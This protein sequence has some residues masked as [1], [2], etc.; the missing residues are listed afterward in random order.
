MILAELFS[1]RRWWA[2]VLKEFLQLRRDRITFA[3]IVAIPFI[4]L[5]LFGYAINSDPKHQPTVIVSDDQ[6]EF[7][8]SFIA[9]LAHSDYF[10]IKGTANEAEAHHLLSQGDAIFVINIPPDFTRRMLRGER[11]ILLVEADATD[12][13]AAGNAVAAVNELALEA[14]NRDLR[15]PLAHLKPTD[16]PFE[17]RIER[18]YNPEG[19][20]QYNIVPGLMGVILTLMMVMMTGLA[21]TRERERGT[22]ENLLATP[23]RSIEVM[24]GKIIPYIAIGIFQAT[25][26]LSAA[27]VLFHV[28][29][30]GSVIA[31][32]TSVLIFVAANLT[33]GVT[34]SSLAS[35]QLQAMQLTIFYFMPNLML[36]GF[37][38]PF[39]GMPA[40]AR[41]LGEFLPLTHFNRLI[42]GIL[43]KGNT[44][45]ELWP[46]LWPLLLFT[47]LVMTVAVKFY[48]KTLD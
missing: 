45:P 25:L 35:N 39:Q 13:M 30:A 5:V 1:F 48:R 29:F 40:W 19:I 11:P 37:M 44:W 16:A 28:P 22:M 34:L 8:R 7:T 32:Y 31:V 26:I 24:A 41:T 43:L 6:S 4:Q 46:N 36:S 33:V 12:P 15:G 47:T 20:S 23:I 27:I 2:V 38:F 18:C 14:F 10:N 3:M 42:R 21:I 9:A 17:L